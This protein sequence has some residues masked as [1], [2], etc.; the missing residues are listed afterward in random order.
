MR[1]RPLLEA[2]AS[3]FT[4]LFAPKIHE[5]RIPGPAQH[6]SFVSEEMVAYFRRRLD[7]A[8]RDAGFALAYVRASTPTRPRSG[9]VSPQALIFKCD[10]LW[11]SS[12]LCTTPTCSAAACPLGAFAPTGRA[13]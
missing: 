4:E 3:S 7:Q 12:T 6:Y 13:E 9:T 5:E 1:D 11:G 2:V 8:P 10:V